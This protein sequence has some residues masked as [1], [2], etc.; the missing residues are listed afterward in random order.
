MKK[1]SLSAIALI[2][3]LYLAALIYISQNGQRYLQRYID[4]QNSVPFSP[5]GLSIDSFSGNIFG[6]EAKA[7]LSVRKE[8]QKTPPLDMLEQDSEVS[9]KILYGPV[10]PAA[11]PQPGI[12]GVYFEEKLS[13][14]LEKSYREAFLSSVDHDPLLSFESI[15]A[16]GTTVREKLRLEGFEMAAKGSRFSLHGAEFSRTFDTLSG[17]GSGLLKSPRIT[18]ADESRGLRVD[19]KDISAAISLP[20]PQEGIVPFGDYELKIGE[21]NITLPSDVGEVSGLFSWWSSLSSKATDKKYCSIRMRNSIHALDKAGAQMGAGL[22]KEESEVRIEKIGIAGLKRYILF[23]KSRTKLS[24]RIARAGRRG[25]LEAIRKALDEIAALEEELVEIFN[26]TIIKNRSR[27]LF[28]T[29]LKASK[30]SHI[31]IELLYKGEALKGNAV[32]AVISLLSRLDRLFDGNFDLR[33]EKEVARRLYPELSLILDSMVDKGLAKVREG[34]YILKG[35]IHDG[36]I[37]IE[38]RSFT[39]QELIFFVLT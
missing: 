32:S 1:F 11:K 12:M 10:V 34:L 38:G 16:F 30:E 25:D 9:L 14:F 27:I 7:K 17:S 13:H 37:L 6:A 15:S 5:F 35:S 29:H 20:K 31:H 39:P 26:D 23:L 18:L 4:A 22:L 21:A 36:R 33:L 28:D 19:M 8:F 2:S 3:F 24:Q